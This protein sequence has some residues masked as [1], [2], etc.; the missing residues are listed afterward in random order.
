MTIAFVGDMNFEGLAPRRLD[1]DPSTAVGPFADVLRGADLA[2]G[3]L[4]TAIGTGGT[5][6]DKQFTFRAP[7]AR[8]RRAAR[9]RASTW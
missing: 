2:V 4:E 9:R 7:P 5:R 6:A 1:A 3:N 8:H